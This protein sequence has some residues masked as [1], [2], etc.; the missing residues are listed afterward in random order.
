MPSYPIIYEPIL[1]SLFW[2]IVGL[3]SN[4]CLSLKNIA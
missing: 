1:G 2:L 4:S 3:V